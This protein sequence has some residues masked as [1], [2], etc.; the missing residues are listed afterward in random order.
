MVQNHTC[1]MKELADEQ[2]LLAGTLDDAG[3]VGQLGEKLNV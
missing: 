2:A 3:G 1:G